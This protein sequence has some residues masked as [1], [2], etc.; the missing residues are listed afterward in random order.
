MTVYNDITIVYCNNDGRSWAR[1]CNNII[2]IIKLYAVTAETQ[3]N[4]AK[5]VEKIEK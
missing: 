4:A 1:D 2:V 5:Y 3:Q